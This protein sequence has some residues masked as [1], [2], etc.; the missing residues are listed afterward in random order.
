LSD[1]TLQTS[2][3]ARNRATNDQR[4]LDEPRDFKPFGH[5][6]LLSVSAGASRRHVP[7]RT[8]I[9][10]PSSNPGGGQLGDG[11]SPDVRGLTP[12]GDR[13]PEGGS[14]LA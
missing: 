7:P 3:R 1:R 11:L 10:A 9:R 13:R 2:S 8:S 6:T 12:P 14:I 5:F 4:R